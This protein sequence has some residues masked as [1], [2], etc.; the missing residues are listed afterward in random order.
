[1]K[2]ISYTAARENLAATM[3][4]V[5]TDHAPVIITRR[6]DQAVVMIGLEDFESM[7][8]TNYLLRSPHNAQRL[9]QAIDQLEN[10]DGIARELAE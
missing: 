2:A 5:C 8:E 1:M 6:R 10:D 4:Q 9:R 7:E 3:D